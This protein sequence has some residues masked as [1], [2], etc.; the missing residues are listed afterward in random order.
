MSEGARVTAKTTG[1]NRENLVSQ[2]NKPNFS[3]SINSPVEQIFF[4]QRTVGNQSVERLL[5]S[6]VIRAKLTIGQPGD[7]Y[8]QEA[9]KVAEQ[10]M[11]M[12][13]PN[14]SNKEVVS[15]QTQL[16]YIQRVCT[17]CEEELQR[18]PIDEEEK[19][20]VLHMQPVE[21][22]GEVLQT[23]KASDQSFE[24]TSE[25][26]SGIYGNRGKGQPL[27][28]SSRSF[29][30]PRFGYDFS[31]VRV[32]TGSESDSLSRS[33][34]ARAFTTGRDIFFRE[35]EYNPGSSD[36][37]E[38]LAHEL[39]HVVQQT[40]RNTSL[41]RQQVP[42]ADWRYT[43]PAT[44]TRSIV[45]IQAIVGTTP[46]GI[47]GPNTRDY[48]KKYQTKLKNVGFYNDII[49]GKWGDN[50][51]TAHIAFAIAPNIERRRYNC[52]G[53]AFKD[54][55]FHPLP[56]TKAIYSTMTQLSNCSDPCK[57]Y[58]HKF[59]FWEFKWQGIEPNG[60]RTHIQPDFHTV[61]GQT[62]SKGEGPY[63]VMSK[64]G[65]RP[66]E[67]PQPPLNWE[68]KSGTPTDQI[69]GQPIWGAYKHVFDIKLKCF[70]NDK[71]P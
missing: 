11:R 14:V 54:Y 13:E 71:L 57:P 53:F 66:V 2:A 64:N 21:E 30:E 18:Q 19:E 67:G 3:Q 9:D 65:E 8:E 63:Q 59:W 70:C 36:S 42:D 44:V 22:E 51:E 35:G 69:T 20:E 38:L 48:V 58:Q 49:D 7:I 12:P 16:P 5:K 32:H 41:Q 28:E 31:H 43:P 25:L 45:E 37:R 68:P 24:I 33:L 47:Y 40:G 46:D 34:N 62:N 61:G 26:E 6:G 52:A 17:E 27:R 4:L 1:A 56:A 23:K 15:G 50:T 10:V 60:R 39:T 29:F 55:Q